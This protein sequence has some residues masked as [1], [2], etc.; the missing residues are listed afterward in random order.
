M[1][2]PAAPPGNNPTIPPN[3][4]LFCPSS[5]KRFSTIPLSISIIG[6]ENSASGS[7]IALSFSNLVIAVWIFSSY[8]PSEATL[9][10]E[11]LPNTP[12]F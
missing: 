1:D 12:A 2:T 11:L 9:A 6:A 10:R 8:K 3:T 5:V 4:M 7:D